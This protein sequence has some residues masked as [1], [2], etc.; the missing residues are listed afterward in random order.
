MPKITAT[1]PVLKPITMTLV[2][3]VNPDATRI[4]AKY[5]RNAGFQEK[6]KPDNATQGYLSTNYPV[7]NDETQSDF[8]VGEMYIDLIK[9]EFTIPYYIIKNGPIINNK[10]DYSKVIFKNQN[11]NNQWIK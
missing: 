1:S 5:L 8:T 10:Y 4:L 9:E 11:L 3:P 7:S 2:D 6:T